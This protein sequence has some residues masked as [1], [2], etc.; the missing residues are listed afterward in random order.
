MMFAV[1]RRL[2]RLRQRRRWC[3]RWCKDGFDIHYLE[4]EFYRHVVSTD[5]ASNR[6]QLLF[7]PGLKLRRTRVDD[8]LD[9]V[10]EEFAA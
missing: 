4:F 1:T 10:Q 8:V 9:A 5:G 3:W 6:V 2:R 7:M